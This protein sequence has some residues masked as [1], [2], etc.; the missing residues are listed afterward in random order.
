MHRITAKGLLAQRRQSGAPSH[1][2]PGPSLPHSSEVPS[3]C[4]AVQGALSPGALNTENNRFLPFPSNAS[5]RGREAQNKK[6]SAVPKGMGL[7]R[8]PVESQ[9][10][11]SLRPS[12]PG[13]MHL[14]DPPFW[15]PR[16]GWA[17]SALLPGGPARPDVAAA[18]ERS[19]C[20]RRE[21]GGLVARPSRPG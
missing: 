14:P 12:L 10:G 3:G 11:P 13:A 4:D 9:P 18:P 6:A 17:A 21:E 8:R 2:P 5:A 15:S 16:R 20:G 19:G 1:L 7:S